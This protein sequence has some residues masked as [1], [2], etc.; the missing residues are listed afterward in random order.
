MDVSISAVEAL[1]HRAK[2]NL[3]KRLSGYYLGEE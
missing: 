3:R 2:R 1:M